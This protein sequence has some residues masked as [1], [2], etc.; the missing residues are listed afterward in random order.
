MCVGFC[1]ALDE[2]THLPTD[3]MITNILQFKNISFFSFFH[4]ANSL[5]QFVV[6]N[7]EDEI[8]ML[9]FQHGFDFYA[10]KTNLITGILT[11]KLL[12]TKHILFRKLAVLMF[13]LSL[14]GLNTEEVF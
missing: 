6:F 9:V 12:Q 10:E 5:L 13:D 14:C 7:P 11:F 1:V 4:R 2:S 3:M 8:F